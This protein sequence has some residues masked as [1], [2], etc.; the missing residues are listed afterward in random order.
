MYLCS[1]VFV[2]VYFA[3]VKVFLSG[4]A[5]HEL[6]FS[7]TLSLWVMFVFFSGFARP[8]WWEGREWRCRADGEQH[9]SFSFFFFFPSVKVIRIV[10]TYNPVRWEIVLKF[11]LLAEFGNSTSHLADVFWSL[12]KMFYTQKKQLVKTLHLLFQS[13][14]VVFS[15]FFFCAI[16]LQ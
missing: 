5:S 4:A 14:V 2:C 3:H 15:H 12:L 8:S 7:L 16:R 13:S 10:F 9:T 1:F 6:Y 11:W